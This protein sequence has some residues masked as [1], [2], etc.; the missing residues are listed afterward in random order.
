MLHTSCI[1]CCIQVATSCIRVAY[2]LQVAYVLHTS[3]NKLH[4]SCTGGLYGGLYVC[5]HT[6]G[7]DE[8]ESD[9]KR[10]AH[11]KKKRAERATS[12]LGLRFGL[13]TFRVRAEGVVHLGLGA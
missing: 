10:P 9:E 2:K 1:Q 7:L 3:C 12:Q 4:T 5:I 6:S 8:E 11:T 13:I